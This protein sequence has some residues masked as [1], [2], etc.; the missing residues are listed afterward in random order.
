[1]GELIVT[2]FFIGNGVAA[3]FYP[4]IGVVIAYLF[5]VMTPQS[6][7]WWHFGPDFRPLMQI[8]IPTFIGIFLAFLRGKVQPGRLLNPLLYPFAI[9]FIFLTVSYFFGPYVEIRNENTFHPAWP[10][11]KILINIFIMLLMGV[12]VIDSEKKLRALSLVLIVTVIYMIYWSNDQYL[13]QHRYGRIGGP[14]Y[15]TGAGGNYADENSFAVLFV[16][17]LPFLY[18]WGHY[19]KRPVLKIAVWLLIPFGWHSVFLTGSRGGLIA[20]GVTILITA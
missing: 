19:L 17:G 20:L 9:L 5:S 7:W 18:Y 2:G 12:L 8:V 16:T 4:W 15:N 14:G 3:I 13:F 10:V 11:F 1:M 6:I